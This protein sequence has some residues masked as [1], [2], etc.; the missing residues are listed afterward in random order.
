MA[1]DIPDYQDFFDP[2]LKTLQFEE[3][4]VY[5]DEINECVSELLKISS[6]QLN[7]SLP[8]GRQTVFENHLQWAL[9]YL[10]QAHLIDTDGA[11]AYRITQAA[12]KQL[13]AN[14][15]IKVEVAPATEIEMPIFKNPSH[16]PTRNKQQTTPEN[17][18]LEFEHLFEELKHDLLQKIQCKEPAFFENLIIDLLLAMGYGSRRRDLAAHLGRT[19]DGGIDGAIN[20]DQLGLDV[21]YIQAK[22]YQ[23]GSS[24][25][26]SAVR[27]FAGAIEAHKA[28]KGVLVTTSTFTKSARVFINQISKRIVL[29]DGDR[30]SELLIRNNIG[31]KIRETYE[32]KR[33][34]EDYFS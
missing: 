33:I 11:S 14:R 4:F 27:D 13:D 17:I 26:V 2:I 20:Q 9:S 28:N 10:V 22:R 6:Y 19:G 1:A 18:S 12:T 8:S 3:G 29:I 7:V 30:L 5:I 16:R 21:V 24:V 23:Q 34:D 15:P 32:V 31:V 25:P